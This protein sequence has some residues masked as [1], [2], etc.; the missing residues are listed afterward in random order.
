M[1]FEGMVVMMQVVSRSVCE[2]QVADRGAGD[3]KEREKIDDTK[4]FH[5]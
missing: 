1:C 4:Q 5:D 2:M 3:E